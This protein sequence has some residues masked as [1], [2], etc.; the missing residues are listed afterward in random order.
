M[1]QTIFNHLAYFVSANGIGWWG[2]DSVQNLALSY[3]LETAYSAFLTCGEDD[4][5]PYVDM[6]AWQFTPASFELLL[7]ELA[8]LKATDWR[9]ELHPVSTGHR[10]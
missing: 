2:Q 9:V 1:K 7:L 5:S 10:R 8:R 3:P 6:H 4:A